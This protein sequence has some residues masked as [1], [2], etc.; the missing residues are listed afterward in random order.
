MKFYNSIKGLAG[1]ALVIGGV[2]LFALS[3]SGCSE[4]AGRGIFL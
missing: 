4:Y 1:K 2:S 3:P